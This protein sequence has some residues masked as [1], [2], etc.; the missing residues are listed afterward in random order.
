MKSCGRINL[1][2][3]ALIDHLEDL[4]KGL[5]RVLIILFLSFILCY[6]FGSYLIEILLDPLREALAKGEG[7]IVHLGLLDKVLAQ[8]QVSFWF[9][10]LLSSPLWFHQI[11]LFV[12]PGLFDYEIRVIRPFIF[13]GFILFCLGVLFGYF[14]VFPLT[15][16]MLLSF[17]ISNVTATIGLK[18]YLILASKVL[19][20]LGL[21]FQ[22]PNIL[23]IL[24]FMGLITKEFLRVNRKYIYMGFAVLSSLLTPPDPYTMLGLWFPLV[25]LYE[26][27][28][29]AVSLIVRPYLDRQEN[30]KD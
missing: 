11:W 25:L 18:D 16:Q 9:S 7:Q 28:I 22:L 12:R 27:G 2:D 3:I 10:I 19:I 30:S 24:G 13:V 1:K 5:I 15:F 29:A 26:I 23:L 20:F 8:I 21:I 17:G 6:V 4:R 14:V